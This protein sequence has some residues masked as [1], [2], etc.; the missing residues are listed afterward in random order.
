MRDRD[1]CRL[2]VSGTW[3]VF[4]NLSCDSQFI[5]SNRFLIFKYSRALILS[6]EMYCKQQELV[7]VIKRSREVQRQRESKAASVQPE[8]M[9]TITMK[10]YSDLKDNKC[11]NVIK[12]VVRQSKA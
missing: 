8:E 3:Y 11:A 7:D 5:F 2:R 9:V 6:I 1:G 4:L 12:Q 10:E